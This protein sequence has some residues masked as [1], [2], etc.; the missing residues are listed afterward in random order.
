MKARFKLTS[1]LISLILLSGCVTT[2]TTTDRVRDAWLP[3][4]VVK[5]GGGVITA[6]KSSQD[7]NVYFVEEANRIILR[8]Q[9]VDNGEIFEFN[10]KENGI[11]EFL[12]LQIPRLSE[13]IHVMS[14]LRF[15]LYF[16]PT[17][18]SK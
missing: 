11:S 15:G 5:V 1:M 8:T 4:G 3:N 10:P 12:L 17:Q 14:E 6:W 18:S 16:L 9:Y 2:P 13:D 7:G